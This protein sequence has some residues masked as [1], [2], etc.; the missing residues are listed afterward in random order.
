MEWE[1]QY[2]GCRVTVEVTGNQHVKFTARYT[3]SQAGPS[4]SPRFD[5]SA[6]LLQR[7]DSE[8]DALASAYEEASRAIDRRLAM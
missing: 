6:C 4:G 8:A 3:T 1:T 7:I 2:E 5:L